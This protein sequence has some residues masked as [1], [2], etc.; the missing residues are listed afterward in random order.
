[1]STKPGISRRELLVSLAA[2]GLLSACRPRRGP[3][4]AGDPCEL[5]PL[6]GAAPVDATGF[7]HGVASGDPR[8]D[9]VVLWTRIEPESTEPGHLERVEYVVARDPALLDVVA[10]G[11]V[12]TS[13]ARD[14]TVKLE[15]DALEPGTR[16]YYRFARARVSPCAF[17]GRAIG[18]TAAPLGPPPEIHASPI[19]RTKTLPIGAVAQVRLGFCS[20]S[21]YAY[22]FF[23]AYAALARRDELDAILHLGDYIYEYA[24]GRYGDGQRLG[25]ALEPSGELV[26]LADYRTR[27]AQTKRDLDLQAAHAAHPF[28]TIWDDHELA[29]NAWIDGAEN[30]D[31]A[32]QGEW[33]VRMAAAIQAYY[34]W[35]PIREP[36][37]TLYRSFRFGELVDLAMLDTRL[38]GRDRQAEPDDLATRNDPARSMLGAEQEAWLFAELEASAKAGVAWRVIGQQVVFG[39]VRFDP[40]QPPGADSWDGYPAAR[41]RVLEQLRREAIRDGVV[42]SGDIHSSWA[43]EVGDDPW[44]PDAPAAAPL[45]VE[46]VTP[47]ISSPGPVPAERAPELEREFLARH[48][49]LRWVE[50]Q[51]RGYVT[52]DI[53]PERIQADW[54][55]M[56][57]VDERRPDERFAKGFVVER[58]DPRL[59]EVSRPSPSKPATVGL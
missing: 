46:F 36:S 43:L 51:T 38:I 29:N 41:A 2:L 4:L 21:N 32:T 27:H 39:Q 16:Y 53:R 3:S 20:C 33:L 7:R 54:W 17:R 24:D 26:S 40:N 25:R 18:P 1:M 50:L 19:G 13:A 8:H 5:A 31:P 35:M 58:G 22:G 56:D 15:V 59:H 11:E 45:L 34:E 42:I 37:P 49:H 10:V 14:F 47:A 6:T 23:N 28:I 57:T 48:P 55:F 9:G 30:H 52:L 12:E 44:V